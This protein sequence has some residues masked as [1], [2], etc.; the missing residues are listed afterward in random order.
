LGALQGFAS[1][2]LSETSSPERD[3]SLLKMKARRLSKSLSR[4]HGELLLFSLLFTHVTTRHSKPNNIS[5]FSKQPQLYTSI[6][7][8]KLN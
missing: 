7:N 2:H 8:V 4:N 3:N 1:S 6:I 5:I